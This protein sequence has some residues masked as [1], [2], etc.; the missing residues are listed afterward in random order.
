MQLKQVNTA[1][2]NITP[3]QILTPLNTCGCPLDVHGKKV[4]KKEFYINWDPDIHLTAFGMKLD[5]EQHRLDCLG[6]VI[7]DEDKLQFCMEQIYES[8]QFNK[9]EMTIWENKGE[10]IKNDYAKVKLYFERL[11]TDAE[12]YAQNSGGMVGKKGYKSA[13]QMANVGDKIRKYIQ[14]IASATV[15]DKEKSTE[16]A[17]NMNESAKKKDAK[18]NVMTMQSKILTDTV[19]ALSKSFATKENINPNG[20]G[21]GGNSGGGGG[22]GGGG[23]RQRPFAYTRNMGAYCWSHGFHPVGANHTSAMCIKEK[24]N[25]KDG[26]TWSKCM[27]GN[28]FWPKANRV[29]PDQ[30]RHVSYK[31]RS[32]PI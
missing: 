31:D 21:G 5:K 29:K 14:E 11:I 24:D 12:T 9:N 20:G 17:A 6:I 3:I 7:S 2:R 25:H 26:A 4:L 1:Y 32:T 13:N 23:G 28:K 19:A 27:G 15:A 16:W 18:I 22:G 8:N 10:L 30:Q